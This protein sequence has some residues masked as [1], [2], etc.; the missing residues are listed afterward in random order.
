[1]MLKITKMASMYGSTK[2]NEIISN[3]DSKHPVGLKE[4][5]EIWNFVCMNKM[6]LIM[7][8]RR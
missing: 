5:S 3:Y 1:M 2:Y 7:D 6:V 8:G 4:E